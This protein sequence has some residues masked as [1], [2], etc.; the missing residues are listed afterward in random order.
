MPP[1]DRR[2]PNDRRLPLLK[3]EFISWVRFREGFKVLERSAGGPVDI[4][5]IG[6]GSECSYKAAPERFRVEP[7]LLR[8]RFE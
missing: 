3:I 6:A 7:T 8:E 2:P 5:G 1:T 4:A